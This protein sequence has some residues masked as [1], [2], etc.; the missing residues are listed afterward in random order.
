[1]SLFQ[2]VMRSDAGREKWKFL[3]DEEVANLSSR[4]MFTTAL[5]LTANPQ[6]VAT[7][8]KDPAQVVKYFGPMHFDLD[9]ANDINAALENGREL[10]KKI[11]VV[12]GIDPSYVDIFL[13]GKKGLHM[14]IPAHVFGVREPVTL[15]PMAW[16][17]IAEQLIVPT[18]DMSIYSMG[19]GRM[20]RNPN[21]R[22]K[23]GTYKVP[24]TLEELETLTAEQCEVLVSAPR[25]DFKTPSDRNENYTASLAAAMYRDGMKAARKLSKK[26]K[27][28]Q[29]AVLENAEELPEVPGCIEKLITEGDCD[30]SNYNQ[31]VMQLAGWIAARFSKSD[32]ETYD[33]LLVE[34]FISNVHSSTRP[35]LQERRQH[36]EDMLERAFAGRIAF[37]RAAVIH[38][39]GGA[40]HNCPICRPDLME[41]KQAEDGEDE[42]FHSDTKIKLTP[43]GYRRVSSTS[44]VRLTSFVFMPKVIYNRLERTDTGMRETD[45]LGMRGDVKDDEGR[46]FYDVD[47]PED[48]WRSKNNLISAVS[49]KG[50]SVVFGSDADLS[51]IQ[52][53]IMHFNRL[54]DMSTMTF[55]EAAGFYLEQLDNG[56]ARPHYVESERAITGGGMPSRFHYCGHTSHVPNL[57]EADPLDKDC[58]E[59]EECLANMANMNERHSIAVIMG[60][61]AA[62]F[63]REHL[64]YNVPEYPSLNVCGNSGAGKSATTRLLSMISGLNYNKPGCEPLSLEV[65]SLVPLHSYVS[66]STTIPRL[67]EE[68]NETQVKRTV[69]TGFINVVKCAWDRTSVSRGT[70]SNGR[71]TGPGQVFYRVSA[72]LMFISEQR[73]QKPAIQERCISVMLSKRGR[74]SSLCRQAF[75]AASERSASLPRIGR[76]LLDLSMTTPPSEFTKAELERQYGDVV[77]E[78]F[79]DR[80]RYSYMIVLM[81]LNQLV[82]ALLKAELTAGADTVQELIE[83]LQQ[84]LADNSKMLSASKRT[85]EVDLCLKYLNAMAGD[86]QARSGLRPGYH[87]LRTGKELKLNLEM[88]FPAYRRWCSETSLSCVFT[89]TEQ[90]AELLMS[91]PYYDRT[92]PHPEKHIP[93]HVI[94]TDVASTRGVSCCHFV[95]S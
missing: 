8:G 26:L 22:R 95:E 63:F 11:Q 77:P 39:I 44:S 32:T 93:L 28:A 86:T 9:E 84:Y 81:G 34:P 72:P 73:P 94:N 35:S 71:G 14:T 38:T 13:S 65:S 55:T 58:S 51:S 4:P 20:W 69:W 50:T 59:V 52:R 91:E 48:A 76:S 18:L 1:M 27:E 25:E 57:I 74:S 15:L 61:L 19:K 75:I 90:L 16:K 79:D 82:R 31:A 36:V 37:S 92:E 10:I 85:S 80:P 62:N 45:R 29:N 89:S 54:E 21:V 64:N 7:T 41:S 49:G 47:I 60:W 66:N 43:Q 30:D 23:C 42:G 68:A 33:S 24:I 2:F 78:D 46:V 12:L 83:D 67:I 70:L 53:A 87:Y 5:K 56:D 3:S 88:I 40:C 17:F 6:Q